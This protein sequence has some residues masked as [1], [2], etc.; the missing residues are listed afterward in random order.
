[1]MS[2]KVKIQRILK[3]KTWRR[4]YI[5]STIIGKKMSDSFY[6]KIYYK[7]MTNRDLD[8][9]NPKT[10]NEKLQ[11]LKLYDRNP[12]YTT[13][14]DKYAVREYIK[15]KIGEEYLI[16]LIGG[17]WKSVDEIPFD[18]LPNQFVLKT[19]HD[20][21][22]V[23]ICNNKKNFD[24]NA[25]KRKLHKSLKNNYYYSGR[26]WPYKN[27]PPQ[28]IAEK[29][30]VDESGTELK[31]YK[32]FN[33][34]GKAKLIQVDYNRFVDHKR[35]LYTPEWEYLDV[36]LQYPNDSQ[37]KI[38][39]P[40]SL[41]KMLE[42]AELLSEGIPHVRTDFYSIGEKIYFGEMTFYHGSGFEKFA[43]P[44]WDRI[45]GDWLVLPEKKK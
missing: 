8:I 17:P 28:I 41:E 2:M 30:M 39:K 24:V 32:I 33:F 12:L 36:M 25:A 43:P 1:M 9:N 6:L 18:T 21:G 42:L 31:D 37:H 38:E 27:V 11:W 16:P 19:T 7:T 4:R 10:F 34:Q 45:V 23:V 20:S 35:N 29:Y 14:V 26:E 44:E 15:E 13:L 3:S 22:G 5:L 40:K